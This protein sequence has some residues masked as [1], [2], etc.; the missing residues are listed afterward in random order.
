L[1]SDDRVE[2]VTGLNAGDHVVVKGNYLL[3]QQ[4]SGEQ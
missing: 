2:I 3:M 4:A 1:K